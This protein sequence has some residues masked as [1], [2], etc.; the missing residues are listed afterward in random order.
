M[1]ESGQV[2]WIAQF[3]KRPVKAT[4]SQ[5]ARS[6]N[7]FKTNRVSSSIALRTPSPPTGNKDGM[8][9]QV[10]GRGVRHSL[11]FSSSGTRRFDLGRVGGRLTIRNHAVV[12]GISG[13]D[14]G[15]EMDVPGAD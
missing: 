5:A 13:L 6:W 10:L 4:V 12:I 1:R 15:V 11:H 7:G 14:S 9:G 3:Q 8:R 2:F